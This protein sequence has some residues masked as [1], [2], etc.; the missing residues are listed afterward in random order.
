MMIISFLFALTL[1]TDIN[2]IASGFDGTVGV[3]AINIETGKT[4]SIRGGERF[5]MGSVFKFPTGLEVLHQVDRGRLRLDQKMTI[6][7]KDFSPGFSPLRD[8]AHGKAI[9]LTLGEVLDAMLR[10][11]DNTAADAFLRMLGADKVTKHLR[12]LGVEGIRVDRTEK[13]MDADLHGK[14]GG[15]A[16]YAVDP[17]D[18]ATPDAT[19]KLLVK[20]A[21]RQEGLSPPSHDLA[22]RMMTTT[23]T[24][25]KRIKSVLPAQATLAHKTGTM[26]G[27]ANDVG[28][29]TTPDGQHIAIAIFTKG[30]K[31]S[32]DE[33]AEKVIAEVA[34]AVYAELTR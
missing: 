22:W 3:S 12:D 8:N 33:Q 19:V 9:T 31:Q 4:I 15:V 2:H 5:P 28:V 34:R 18:T 27:T 23:A 13:M 21:R 30:R 20:F 32:T 6:E 14:P 16:R 26:P 24:G 17:R 10:V 1:T 7:P 11:S 29:I 25:P